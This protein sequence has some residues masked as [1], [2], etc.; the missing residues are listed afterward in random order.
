MLRP[1][2]VVLAVGG[3]TA[4]A[5]GPSSNTVVAITAR[6]YALDAPDT[7]AS[8]WTRFQ[9]TNQGQETHFVVFHHVPDDLTLDDYV[10]QLMPPFDS[11]E[12]ALQRGVPVEEAMQILTAGL[13]A[14][15]STVHEMGGAGLVAPGHEEQFTVRLMPGTYV[16]ECYVR[17]RDGRF[18]SS[19]GM[20]H[21]LTVTQDSSTVEPPDADLALTVSPDGIAAPGDV[22]AGTHTV[23]VHYQNQPEG[24]VGYDVHLAR[25]A[26]GQSAEDVIPWMNWIPVTGLEAPA[27]V[28]F[29][30]GVQE[31][32]SGY[33]AYF[34]VNIPAGRYVWVSELGADQGMVDTFTVD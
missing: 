15:F 24:L 3:L 26:E 2:L 16:L 10:S 19:L 28:E 5:G 20:L 29:L 7:I 22:R 23:A 34:T 11:T 21:Q 9:F 4:C 31:M 14:W 32:P 13:P 1:T 8:G 33:T 12:A 6:D 30:G 18:H 17:N 25:L 27:P